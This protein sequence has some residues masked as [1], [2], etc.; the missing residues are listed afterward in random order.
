MKTADMRLRTVYAM[1][2]DSW[3]PPSPVVILSTTTKVQKNHYR[4][5]QEGSSHFREVDDWRRIGTGLPAVEIL[6]ALTP[7]TVEE[8]MSLTLDDFLACTEDPDL[9]VVFGESRPRTKFIIVKSTAMIKG[10]WKEVAA[11]RQAAEDEKQAQ[12]EAA[13]RRSAEID[14]RVSRMEEQVAE[15]LGAGSAS[16]RRSGDFCVTIPT[17]LLEQLL[18]KIRR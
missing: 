8:A 3:S 17:D 12:R 7:A 4:H 16:V 6:G 13:A 10:P 18:L 11:A 5:G 14:S 1:G 9:A 2:G 15:V